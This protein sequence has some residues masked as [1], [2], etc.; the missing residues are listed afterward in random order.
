MSLWSFRELYKIRV[1]LMFL[2]FEAPML[3]GPL[4]DRYGRRPVFLICLLILIGS[5]IGL[6]LCPTDA[7]WLLIVL[8]LLQAGGCA[9]TV[10][11][12]MGVCGDI[13]IP[14]ERGGFVG[15]FSTGPMVCYCDLRKY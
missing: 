7:F 13:S 11:L 6:A 12:G 15:F 1:K 5:C 3:W 9:S 2:T 14:E 8:R 4:S 10:S